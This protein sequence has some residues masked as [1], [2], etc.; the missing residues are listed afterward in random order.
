M[1][2][3]K[4]GTM[5]LHTAESLESRTITEP[6]TGCWLFTGSLSQER[7]G[8]IRHG[9]FIVLA[10]RLMYELVTGL[11]PD[12]MEVCHR[13]DNPTCCNPDH[14]FLGTH[15]ENMRDSARKGRSRKGEQAKAAKRRLAL[16]EVR[17]IRASILAGNRLVDLARKYGVSVA[18]I[19][20]IGRMKTWREI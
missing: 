18:A 19:S 4:P 14:L 11:R 9:W 12:G 13:C 8:K 16:A 1:P 17:T 3:G 10:H 5:T 7:Y 6:N 2:Y 20:N 15:A